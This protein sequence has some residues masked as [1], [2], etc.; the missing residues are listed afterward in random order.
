[1]GIQ[2]YN[3]DYDDL[4]PD[5]GGEWVKYAD[6][7]AAL[8]AARLEERYRIRP[9]IDAALRLIGK[10]DYDSG[11]LADLLDWAIDDYRDASTKESPDAPAT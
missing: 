4:C 9:V 8:A 5:D 1:M 11:S 6:H 10:M 2:R 3:P 7:L